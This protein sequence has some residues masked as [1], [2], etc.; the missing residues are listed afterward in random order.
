ME[1]NATVYDIVQFYEKYPKYIGKIKVETFF[2]YKE[3]EYA[4]KTAVQS[5]VLKVTLHN[6]YYL[7]CS[8]NH[9]IQT[10]NNEWVEA[11][12]LTTES[13]VITDVGDEKVDKIELMPYNIDLYDLQVAEVKQYF[14]NGICS[15]NSTILDALTFVLFGKSFRGTKKEFLVNTI[16]K[17]NCLVEI[18]FTNNGHNYVVKRGI[19]KNVFEI[20]V[21]NV[22]L[23]QDAKAYDYQKILEDNILKLNYKT[24]T[25]VVILGSANY[26]PF[27]KL[28]AQSRREIVEDILGIN[29][30]SE[31]NTLLKN[32]YSENQILIAKCENEIN[33]TKSKILAQQKIIDTITAN[34]QDHIDSLKNE[35]NDYIEKVTNQKELINDTQQKI[36]QCKIEENNLAYL[37]DTMQKMQNIL[38]Y[39]NKIIKINASKV[40][41]FTNIDLCE[42]C[43][44]VITPE[45]RETY[46]NK[47]KTT[48]LQLLDDNK[49]TNEEYKNLQ[50][51][52]NV[53]IESVRTLKYLQLQLTQ[54]LK[55]NEQFE[56]IIKTKNKQLNEL[57]NKQKEEIG[58]EQQIIQELKANGLQL[59]EDKKDLLNTQQLMEYSLLLLKDTGIKTSIISD[60]IDSIN[61][62]INFYLNKFECY[63][64]FEFDVYFNEI[65]KSRFRDEFEYASLSQ[66]EQ[67]RVNLSIMLAWRKICISKNVSSTNL[68]VLDEIMDSSMDADGVESMINILKEIEHDINIFILTPNGSNIKDKFRNIIEVKKVNDFSTLTTIENS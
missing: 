32:E 23:N 31:M 51:E 61:Q 43:G 59:I 46:I 47:I 24:F 14:S 42:S 6:G 29:I 48:S 2:G 36:N 22:L 26:V 63:F 21:D 60:Y 27:M 34:K 38:N 56:K 7:E 39:N 33:I 54:Y 17:K 52:Y 44:Q 30:F 37:Y 41:D 45:Y 64:S 49:K 16:N 9:L 10:S 3:I 19:K 66:G 53:L 11:Q 25:Q 40:K 18:E 4:S 55:Q 50:Q 57:E 12:N 67:L 5:K 20:W 1:L 13:I 62:L 65:I 28:N 15:H 8:P 68:L 58:N 35:I